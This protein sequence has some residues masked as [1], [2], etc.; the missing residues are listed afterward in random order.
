MLIQVYAPSS[1]VTTTPVVEPVV[2]E[3]E[4]TNEEID[5]SVPE[6]EQL[7]VIEQQKPVPGLPNLVVPPITKS[8]EELLNTPIKD[9]PESQLFKLIPLEARMT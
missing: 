4:K 7:V 8:Q 5:E 1:V 2:L 3:I 6:K 9:I